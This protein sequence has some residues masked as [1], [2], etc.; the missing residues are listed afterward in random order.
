MVLYFLKHLPTKSSSKIP[1]GVLRTQ[2]DFDLFGLGK[3]TGQT[4]IHLI[5]AYAQVGQIL[6]GQTA[7]ILMDHDAVPVTLDYWGPMARVFNFNVQLRYM[8]IWTEEKHLAFS[9]ERPG[10]T[11]DG[12]DGATSIQLNDVKPAFSVP[13][14][15]AQYR[16]GGRWGHVQLAA[17]VKQL[18]WYD[19]SG[20][21]AQNLS[22]STI[23]WGWPL[24]SVIK[25]I[26]GL[27][28]K[29]QVVQ[30]HGIESHIADVPADL[31]PTKN[32]DDPTQPIKGIAQ[33]VWG[34]YTFAEINWSPVLAT[35]IGYSQETVKTGNLQSA[36]AFRKG[37][38]G[39]GNLRWLPSK[40]I[41][42]G[43]E[44]QYGKRQ[45]AGNGFS[46][47]GNKLQLSAKY[48]FSSR[49]GS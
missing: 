47:T 4:T 34:Y 29:M 12:G 30:G 15:L 38:Y 28:L 1:Y 9:V 8:P 37:R 44:Y 17:M 48:S 20:S 43:I 36:D 25:A 23:G 13:N 11:A 24:S 22:G 49:A 27:T 39:L 26:E 45:N 32:D 7:S 33:P 42:I 40:T 41:M 21:T 6:F 18:K 35:T 31:V 14:I 16:Q 10:A 46:A 3:N 2:L 19:A 5:N